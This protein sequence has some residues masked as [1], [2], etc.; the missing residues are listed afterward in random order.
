MRL[1]LLLLLL[2]MAAAAFWFGVVPLA[3]S[4]FARITL[5]ERPGIFVDPRLAML[6]RNPALCAA[7]LK[8]PHIEATPIRDNPITKGC[9]WVNSVGVANAGGARVGVDKLTCEMA[10][11]IALWLEYEVQ[12]LAE[13]MFGARVASLHDM[14]TYSCRDI[15]GNVFWKDFRSQH[16]TANAYDVGGFT[17]A[18]GRTISVLRNWQKPDLEGRFLHEAH[19]RA[20]RYF[21]VALSPNFN[22]AHRDHLHFDRGFLWTCR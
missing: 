12:P 22:A 16:A 19:R 8:P 14:G 6:R 11:A 7:V 18:D 4:P 1:F 5:D 10:A 3:W 21:R 17:L 9:G 13:K 2:L 20:C 15:I